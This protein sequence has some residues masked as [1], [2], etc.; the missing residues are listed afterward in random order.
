MH[1]RPFKKPLVE[2]EVPASAV[3]EERMRALSKLFPKE[4][5]QEQQLPKAAGPVGIIS[6]A[7]SFAEES[8]GQSGP[9][10]SPKQPGPAHLPAQPGPANLPASPP[11][12]QGPVNFAAKSDPATPPKH[13]GPGQALS[14]FR[15]TAWEA[16]TA[17]QELPSAPSSLSACSS[18]GLPPAAEP[19]AGELH[20]SASGQ[21]P[22][23]AAGHDSDAS[24]TGDEMDA[25]PPAGPAPPPPP[26]PMSNMTD[27]ELLVLVADILKTRLPKKQQALEP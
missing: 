14:P 13:S 16:R 24:I 21:E 10:A 12:R 6:I 19:H 4:E 5:R 11:Q 7:G 20:P 18:L 9:A 26:A 17:P 15:S 2:Y 1:L 3:S 27:E 25:D 22:P 23:S 8:D